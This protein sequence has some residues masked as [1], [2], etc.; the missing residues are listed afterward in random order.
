MLTVIGEAERASAISNREA[1]RGSCFE[2][3]ASRILR[4]SSRSYFPASRFVKRLDIDEAA[5][6]AAVADLAL[7]LEGFDL[8]AD[9]A[10][11]HGDDLSRGPHRRADQRRAEMADIDLGPD[12]DPAGLKKW[13]LMASLDA[14][15]ISRIIIGVA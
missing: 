4:M 15:S 10:A 3:R 7:A 14:I 13:P 1:Q 5:G 8:E 11:L 12:R 6:V 2:T 9:D